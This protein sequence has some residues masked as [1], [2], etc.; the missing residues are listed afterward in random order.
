MSTALLQELHQEIR[1]LY[2]AGSGLAAGDF[3]LKRLLPQFQQLGNAH[4]SLRSWARAWL[5]Y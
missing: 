5:H 3:R 2:I 4:Q 1:R